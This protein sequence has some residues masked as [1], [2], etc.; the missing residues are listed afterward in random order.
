MEINWM[1]AYNRLFDIIHADGNQKA[2]QYYSGTKFLKILRKIDYSIPRNYMAYMDSR[3]KKDLSTSRVDYYKELLDSLT[4]PKRLEVYQKF[5]SKLEAFNLPE[6]DGLKALFGNDGNEAVKPVEVPEPKMSD[7]FYLDVLNT[8]NSG[9]K[10]LE[11]K[12]KIYQG[13]GEE[14]IRDYLMMF[15]ETRYSDT[16]AT[17]ESLNKSGKTDILLKHIDNS[18]LFVAECKI[19]GGQQVFFDA[20]NQLFDLY[21]TWRDSKAALL[22]FVRN[23]DFSGVLDT[24]KNEVV[25]HPYYVEYTRDTDESSFSYIF[26]LPGDEERKVKFE[27]MAFHFPE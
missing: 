23:K 10:G 17:R 2:P 18:N 8:I 13:M 3:R 24:I 26:H 14:D 1:E 25:N 22:L 4:E 21:L 19:W 5:I 6:L 7:N 27:I 11:Q 20:I 16:T 12:K 15:L 9:L